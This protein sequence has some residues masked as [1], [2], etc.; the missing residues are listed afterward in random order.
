MTEQELTDLLASDMVD[1]AINGRIVSVTLH[2]QL[3]RVDLRPQTFIGSVSAWSSTD[4]QWISLDPLKVV[5]VKPH[6][7]NF[8]QS[9]NLT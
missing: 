6:Q 4:G 1:V 9:L 8:S 2:P 7:L 3:C 5:A